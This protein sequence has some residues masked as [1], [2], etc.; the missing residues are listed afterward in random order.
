[1]KRA[2]TQVNII[3]RLNYFFFNWEVAV[4]QGD[5]KRSILVLSVSAD[6]LDS[7][8]LMIR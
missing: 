1:M 8:L 5:N 7:M 4:S 6:Y 2:I 3:L